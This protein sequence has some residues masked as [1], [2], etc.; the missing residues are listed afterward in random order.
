MTYRQVSTATLASQA[1][2]L[3]DPDSKSNV[4]PHTL[5]G[6]KNSSFSA[7]DSKGEKHQSVH[8]ALW[9]YRVG[10][11]HLASAQQLPE[12]LQTIDKLEACFKV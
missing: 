12:L 6:C 8:P 10:K 9:G 2:G 11:F 5:M 3:M 7:R 1:C 4:S